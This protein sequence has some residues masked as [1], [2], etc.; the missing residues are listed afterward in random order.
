MASSQQHYTHSKICSFNPQI[1]TEHLST[2]STPGPVMGIGNTAVKES[3]PLGTYIQDSEKDGSVGGG[4]LVYENCVVHKDRLISQWNRSI[5]N[6]KI[7]PCF[8]VQLI[9]HKGCQD[10]SLVKDN[11]FNKWCWDNWISTCKTIQLDPYLTLQI[12]SKWIKV[13]NVRPKTIKLL[14][15]NIRV[16]FHE[17]GSGNGFLDITKSTATKEKKSASWTAQTLKTF[18]FWRILS[19][20]R[21]DNSQNGRKYL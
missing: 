19:R 3:W 6:S 16:K 21:K 13:L 15:E 20:R 11:V 5:E 18:V 17:L 1:F 9:F 12:N 7:N 14:G 4:E 2:Y 8:C 10:Y